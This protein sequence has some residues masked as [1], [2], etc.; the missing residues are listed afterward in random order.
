MHIKIKAEKRELGKKSDLKN[1]RKEG[2]IPAVVYGEGKE[3]IN[4]LLP[5]IPFQKAYKKSIGEVAIFEIEVGNKKYSTFI[6]EKQIHPVSREF[7][8]IDFVELHKGKHITMEIPIN[9]IGEP[10][11]VKEGGVVEYLHRSLEITCLPKDLPEEIDV[12]ITELHVG[13]TLHFSN[14]TLPA[15]ISCSLSGAATIIAIKES[16]MSVE[17]NKGEATTEAA[18]PADNA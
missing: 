11:G 8:H 7:V 1:Y 5:V 3:G 2:F 4:I 16:R 10:K 18:A 6:K 9:F 17:S 14:I 15:N 12:D 13:D